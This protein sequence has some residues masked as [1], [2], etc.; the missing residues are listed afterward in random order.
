[1]ILNSPFRK[2]QAKVIPNHN[3]GKKFP[4]DPIKVEDI[5]KLL[6]QFQPRRA[7][8]TS[9]LSAM[10]LRALTAT[11]WR[12]GLRI[13]E[14]LDLEER[15]LLRQDMALVVRH[16]KGDKR[17]LVAMD[18]WGWQELENWLEVRQHLPGG[19]IFCVIRGNTAGN[20]AMY[21]SDVRRQLRDAAKFAGIN[22]RANPH[23]FRHEHAVE[24]WR[25]G[26]DVYTIQQQLGHARLD[27]TAIYLK[28]IAPVEL[29]EPIGRLRRPPMMLINSMV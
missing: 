18:E 15:D 10:R 17:R 16:G 7:G 14:A 8:Y 29:L 22:R 23:S 24:L 4:P 2:E 28:G 25:E 19:K 21:D 20:K 11:L 12:T 6:C 27:V 13:S 5:V 3:K 26:I 9:Q 1:M